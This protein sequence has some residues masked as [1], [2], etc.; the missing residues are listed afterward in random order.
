MSATAASCKV[1]RNQGDVDAAFAKASAHGRREYY[2]P[3]M[4]HIAMEPPVALVNVA[5]GKV[6]VGPVQSPWGTRQDVSEKLGVPIENVTVHV[7]LLGGGFGAS[8]SATMCSRRRSSRRRWAR[9]SRCSGPARTTSSTAST[10][11]TSVERIEAAIDGNGKVTGW[12][13]RSVAPSIISTFKADDGH[14]FPIEYGMGFAD[15]PFEIPNVRS[16]NG[17]AMAYTRIGWF[18]SVSNIPR[19]FAVQSFAAELANE[20][21]AIRRSSFSS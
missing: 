14:Q 12:R 9:R 13:H 18:R 16:E 10:Y 15:M 3:H 4:A 19:A 20:L 21:A 1:I 2:Q 8:R 7:T 11:T 6:E 5:D 17:K